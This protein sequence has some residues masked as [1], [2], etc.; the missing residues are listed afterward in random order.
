MYQVMHWAIFYSVYEAPQQFP[1]LQGFPGWGLWAQM[2]SVTCALLTISKVILIYP[3][4]FLLHQ[5]VTFLETENLWK[6]TVLYSHCFPFSISTAGSL[7]FCF[8]FFTLVLAKCNHHMRIYKFSAGAEQ[9]SAPKQQKHRDIA[10]DSFTI[11]LEF[12]MQLHTVCWACLFYHNTAAIHLLRNS[13]KICSS[14]SFTY[15]CKT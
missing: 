7:F 2:E 10:A 8:V 13:I 14:F 15:V 4:L 9:L 11:L 5:F 3:F 6:R 1:A 12:Y